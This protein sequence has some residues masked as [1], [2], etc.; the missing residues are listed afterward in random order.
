MTLRKKQGTMEGD[1]IP[2]YV[3]RPDTS[4]ISTIERIAG[5]HAHRI[6]VVE[7]MD[8]LAGVISLSD[9]MPLL[10]D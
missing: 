5:T 6:W 1:H 3:I 7:E 4:L 9:I 2:S 8:R 10:L